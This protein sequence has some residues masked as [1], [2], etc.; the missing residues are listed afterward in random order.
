MTETSV[1]LRQA[2]ASDIPALESLLNRCYRQNEGWTNESALIGGI[3][4]TQKELERVISDP[5]HYLFAFPKTENGTRDG[6][7]TGEILGC[8]NVE[9]GNN[10][11]HIGMFAVNP[12]LQGNGVGNTML[13][14]AET[15]AER[16]LNHQ[17]SKNNAQNEPSPM[18]IKLLVLTGRPQLQAYYERRGYVAT[19]NTEAFPEDG[20]N[21][22]PKKEG[23]YFLELAKIIE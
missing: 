3:R 2:M 14:A 11:A 13:E 12:E 20:N 19:G 5:N 22:T 21:G 9:M 7:E 16:H 10:D 4:T 6:E 23:L 17:K 15:F 8:I 1:F 18:V